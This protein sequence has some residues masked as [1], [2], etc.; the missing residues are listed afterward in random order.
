MIRWINEASNAA[1]WTYEGTAPYC[2][3]CTIP[4]GLDHYP[5]LVQTIS[6]VDGRLA[7][8][9]KCRQRWKLAVEGE[10]ENVG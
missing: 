3:K 4:S 5:Y 10:N 9:P 7:V 6:T 8:C 1:T 2:N